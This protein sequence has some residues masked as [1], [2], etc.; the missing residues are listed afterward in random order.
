MNQNTCTH[1]ALLSMPVAAFTQFIPLY[2]FFHDFHGVHTGLC[3]VVMLA[4][5][6]LLVWTGDRQI[7]TATK[8]SQISSGTSSVYIV[9]W[10]PVL[11]SLHDRSI[12]TRPLIIRKMRYITVFTII[13]I[14]SRGQ[15]QEFSIWWA[16]SVG[17]SP[18]PVL[19]H[20]SVHWG[21]R[22]V[23]IYWSTRASWRLWQC[24]LHQHSF[25]NCMY[26]PSM[27]LCKILWQ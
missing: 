27:N 7:G 11:I 24:L 5:Y 4:L 23:S 26:T 10:G 15:E 25:R 3:L 9:H 2:H 22:E 20:P 17:A 1:S 6:L 12:Y 14:H 16:L 8:T 21:S 13:V 18:L 19:Y